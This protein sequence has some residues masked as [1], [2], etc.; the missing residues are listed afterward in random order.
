MN[1]T[2]LNIHAVLLVFLLAW[3]GSG[4]AQD[5]ATGLSPDQDVAAQNRLQQ[6]DSLVESL[7][8]KRRARATVRSTMSSADQDDLADL[9]ASVDKLSEDIRETS[10]AIEQIAVGSVDLEVLVDEQT[11]I[12][13]RREL[14]QILTP[15]LQS[16]KRVTEKPRKIEQERNNIAQAKEQLN[17]AQVAL[18]NIEASLALTEV[19]P[20][21]VTLEGLSRS[22]TQRAEEYTRDLDVATAQ[23]INLQRS[24]ESLWVQVRAAVS[25][26]LKGRGLT[27]L[28]AVVA[29]LVVYYSVQ[30]LA[31]AL[32]KRQKGEEARDHR[33]RQR[34]IHFG[35]RAIKAVLIAVAII[36]VFYVR[37][38]ILLM[39][40]SFLLAAAVFVSARH[41]IPRFVDE[42][43]LLLNLGSVRED[44]RVMYHG[45]PWKVTQLNVHSLLKNPE[46]TGVLR[47]PMNE[48]LNLTSRPAG[49]EPWFPASKGDYILFDDN[50]L[51]QVTKLTPEHV[52]LENLAGTST[53][54]P[55]SEFYALV[56]ENLTRS[57]T[58]FVSSVF[59]I[60]YS[61][62][63]DSVHAIP[64]KLRTAIEQELQ[65]SDVS[66]H[67]V[68]VHAE[69]QEAGAS[70]LDFWLGVKMKREA[71]TSYFKLKRQIQ[72]VCVATCTEEGWEI[73]FPQLVLHQ[74]S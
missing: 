61:H 23:L 49:S 72:Q 20:T 26:F 8:A 63:S 41:V 42:L 70:S 69:L 33:T 66:Q 57:P 65:H 37:G 58:Y 64:E 39:A 74:P 34:I 40:L 16:L 54:I 11:E 68:S 36:M 4:L 59:G 30:F 1:S 10:V 12:D 24:D 21:R 52:L 51:L 5:S 17:T 31:K 35:V 46:I 22:W 32:T 19:G 13:W 55:T 48:M 25:S 44:E 6:I 62:Q 45:L 71:A 3:P 50:R 28:L 27:L 7:A 67:V 60:G 15:V 53:M 38:D 56:F 14:N 9:Q 47:V 18:S 43:K 29:S 2:V 73:P